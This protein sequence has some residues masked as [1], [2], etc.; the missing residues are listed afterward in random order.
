MN[1]YQGGMVSYLE[2][3]ST[4]S[5][6]LQNERIAVGIERRRMAASVALV[7]ALGG[8]WNAASLPQASSLVKKK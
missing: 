4:Q 5:A 3:I 2:V 8:G 6:R 1:R 7:R